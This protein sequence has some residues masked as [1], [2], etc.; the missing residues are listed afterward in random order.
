MRA[1]FHLSGEFM[2]GNL[3]TEIR[4]DGS[5]VVRVIA[6]SSCSFRVASRCPRTRVTLRLRRPTCSRPADHRD[7][8]EHH[9]GAGLC[10]AGARRIHP[11][12]RPADAV[13][14][15]LWPRPR[16]GGPGQGLPDDQFKPGQDGRVSC[17]QRNRL[18]LAHFWVAFA[19]FARRHSS[20]PGRCGCAARCTRVARPEQY[21]MSVTAHGVR[22]PTSD[23]FFIMGFGYLSARARSVVRSPASPGR[24][25]RSGW[26]SSA[27]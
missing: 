16:G 12:R 21:F 5:A 24:G 15:V 8:R 14:R 11:W 7:Q 9:G 10:R 20:A 4:P 19:A 2:E 13:S 18:V 26:R 23:Q 3:G 17:A 22:W 6:S 25:R 1:A 27:S